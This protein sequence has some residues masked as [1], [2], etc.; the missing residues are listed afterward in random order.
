MVSLRPLL[1]GRSRHN[2]VNE[3]ESIGFKVCLQRVPVR[4]QIEALRSEVR[5][6][7]NGSR[8]AL[9]DSASQVG[10]IVSE[11][12]GGLS[13]DN[14]GARL[15]KVNDETTSGIPEFLEE[16]VKANWWPDKAASSIVASSGLPTGE[17]GDD[18]L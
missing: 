15:A 18:D 10:C 9:S 8:C 4:I 5:S 2:V 11:N 7:V 6:K 16:S 14:P 13:R 12:F 1:A 3:F 17:T